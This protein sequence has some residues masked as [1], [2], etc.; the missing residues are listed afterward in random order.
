MNQSTIGLVQLISDLWPIF[1]GFVIAIIWFIRLE[2]KVLFLRESHKDHVEAVVRKDAALW[3]KV[4][5]L[6]ASIT[7]VLQGVARLEGKMDSH[8]QD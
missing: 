6:Q 2:A 5:S 3:A 1:V 8:R 7:N 4:D